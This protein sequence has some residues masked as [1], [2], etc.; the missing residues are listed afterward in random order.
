MK[1]RIWKAHM[2]KALMWY[3]EKLHERH[4][5][6]LTPARIEAIRQDLEVLQEKMKTSES[7]PVWRAS[8]GL[9]VEPEKNHFEVVIVD[10]SNILYMDPE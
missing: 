2:Q 4:M 7:N 3:T 6:L 1:L 10:D 8:V 9:H 5:A